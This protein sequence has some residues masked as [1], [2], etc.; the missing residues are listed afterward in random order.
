[1]LSSC[2]WFDFS[3]H[4]DL[5]FLVMWFCCLLAVLLHVCF[6]GWLFSDLLGLMSLLVA[7]DA[8]GFGLML[9]LFMILVCCLVLFYSLL[10]F[11]W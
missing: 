11:A 1:M 10:L 5:C 3:I 6:V 2:F 9:Y 7:C 4:L 8:F